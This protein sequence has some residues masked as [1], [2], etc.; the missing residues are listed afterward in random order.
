MNTPLD[1]YLLGIFVFCFCMAL[2][3]FEGVKERREK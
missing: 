2:F 3:Y 1:Y